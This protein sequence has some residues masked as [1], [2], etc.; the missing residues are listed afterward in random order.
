MEHEKCHHQTKALFSSWH[1]GGHR[2][3]Y[4]F[5]FLIRHVGEVRMHR[6]TTIFFLI[7]LF[8]FFTN[9][10]LNFFVVRHMLISSVI[11]HWKRTCWLS[12]WSAR[13][14][15]SC[16]CISMCQ[17][18]I[19]DRIF[20]NADS[21]S[22]HAFTHSCGSS[23]FFAKR[24][25]WNRARAPPPPTYNTHTERLFIGRNQHHKFVG[26][27]GRK[28][29]LLD[30]VGRKR[31]FT[32]GLKCKND[33]KPKNTTTRQSCWSDQRSKAETVEKRTSS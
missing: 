8:V 5:I 4:H 19:A 14:V 10:W 24:T 17:P 30:S 2:Q 28:T 33:W 3:R 21:F 6:I 29:N 22:V 13:K 27:V 23:N 1:A 12:H 25:C 18:A 20:C 11:L 16:H 9:A 31:N 26:C 15:T 32:Q 7:L